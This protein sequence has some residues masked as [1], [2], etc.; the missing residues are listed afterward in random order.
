MTPTATTT[1]SVRTAAMD[2]VPGVAR[3]LGRAFCED[4]LFR[5][6]FP[7]P[8]LRMAR[9]V[10]M[11]ALMAGFGY[12]PRGHTSVFEAEEAGRRV[13]RGAALW[14]PP[15]GD[16]EGLAFTLRALP[17]LASLVGVNRL[18]EVL[19]YFAELKASAPEEPHWYLAV[20]GTDPAARGAGVGSRLLREGLA[21]AD[22]DGVPVYLETMNPAN[23]GYY[24]KYDFRV[25]RAINDPGLPSTYCML[26][27]AV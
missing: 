23:I 15:A 1:K 9:S 2:D 11:S 13:V 24:E 22:A 17:H 14:A 20:L 6:L 19:R 10:R 27:P 4:P 3:V 12:V 5:W 7:E 18:P 21:Q 8:S 16:G 25:M 26:R